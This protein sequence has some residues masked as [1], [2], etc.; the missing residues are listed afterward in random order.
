MTPTVV[1]IHVAA[2]NLQATPAMVRRAAA[3]LGIEP[4]LRVN[5]IDCYSERDCDRIAHYIASHRP[6]GLSPLNFPTPTM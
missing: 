3:A 5:G 1:S 2:G 6:A 4:Q